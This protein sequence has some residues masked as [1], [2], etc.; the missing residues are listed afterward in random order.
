MSPRRKQPSAADAEEAS[1]WLAFARGDIETAQAFLGSTA[2]P[3]RNTAYMA[4]QAA[5]KAIKAVILLDN[6]AFEMTHDLAAIQAQAPSDFSNPASTLDLAW[7]ADIETLARYPD[8]GDT[9]T[10]DDAERAVGIANAILMAAASHFGARG[11][12]ESIIT[13]G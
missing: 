12:D 13:A 4:Q 6:L 8:E 7:L 2:V 11:V 1:R 9:V 3:N 10:S 5:E